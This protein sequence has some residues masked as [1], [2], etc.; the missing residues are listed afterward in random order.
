MNNFIMF[1]MTHGEKKA[2]TPGMKYRCAKTGGWGRDGAF[3]DVV[4]GRLGDRPGFRGH[5]S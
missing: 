3:G 2:K 4:V 1:V 5:P